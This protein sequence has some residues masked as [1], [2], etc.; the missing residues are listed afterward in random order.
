MINEIMV[1]KQ[2][3]KNGQMMKNI[4]F[5]LHQVNKVQLYA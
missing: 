1:A 4:H 5:L 3:K 2:R